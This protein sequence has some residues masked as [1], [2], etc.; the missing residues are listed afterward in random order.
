VKKRE[1]ELEQLRELL[2]IEELEKSNAKMGSVVD[3]NEYLQNYSIKEK[4]LAEQAVLL[5]EKEK[6]MFTHKKALDEKEQAI[7]EEYKKIE[8]LMQEITIRENK[9]SDNIARY[10]YNR[11]VIEAKLPENTQHINLNL[12]LEK[13]GLLE[14][15]EKTKM[16]EEEFTAQW[17]ALQKKESQLIQL[18]KSILLRETQVTRQKTNLDYLQTHV[19]DKDTAMKKEREEMYRQ[20]KIDSERLKE[21]EEELNN[22]ENLLDKKYRELSSIQA[23]I[24]TKSK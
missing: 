2:R 21:K 8:Y 14:L 19:K 3:I 23:D 13:M 10:E 22:K 4:L 17:I 9:L 7:K 5:Q 12:K 16:I 18:Q 6:E 24:L 1:E 15:E 11:A 20:V